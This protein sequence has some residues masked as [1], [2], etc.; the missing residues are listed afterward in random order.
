MREKPL[1]YSLTVET[2]S[3]KCQIATDNWQFLIN[4][5]DPFACTDENYQDIETAVKRAQIA[6]HQSFKHNNRVSPIACNN[7]VELELLRCYL[8]GM[9]IKPTVERIFK[10]QNH[11]TSVA[12]VGRYWVRLRKIGIL[13]IYHLK[14]NNRLKKSVIVEA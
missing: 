9:Q 10:K 12:S 2:S 1:K 11:K 14:T 6:Y 7:D 3:G 8:R 4:L 13:P 5:I